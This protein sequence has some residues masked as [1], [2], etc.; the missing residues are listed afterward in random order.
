MKNNIRIR[1][2]EGLNEYS[3]YDDDLDNFDDLDMED[4]PAAPVKKMSGVVKAFHGSPSKIKSFSDEF[5]GGE[6]ANDQ[7]GPGIYFTT[8]YNDATGYGKGG[9]VY[10]V[11]LNIKNLV[12]DQP[13]GSLD[14]LVGPVTKLIKMNPNWKSVAK[15]YDEGL[16]EMIAQYL[17]TSQSEKEVFVAVCN[18]IYTNDSVSFVRNMVKLG[19]DGLHLPMKGD[20]ANIVIYNPKLIRVDGVKQIK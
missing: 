5:V 19:Y 10:Q 18:S 20:G 13:S 14:Y 8:D 15:G 11:S 12:S 7:E 9:Y 1:L 2:R 16:G 17:H 4:E 6:E 3:E